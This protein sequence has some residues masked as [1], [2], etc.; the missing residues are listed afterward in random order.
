NAA[1]PLADRADD[2]GELLRDGVTHG[3]RNIDRGRAGIDR[4]LHKA[5]EKIQV[6]AGGVF[7]REFHVRAQRPGVGHGAVYLFKRLVARDFELALQMQIRAGQE[8]VDPRMTGLIQRSPRA[9][10]V[11][12]TGTGQSSNNRAAE[13]CGD[14]VY[15]PEVIFRSYGKTR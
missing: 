2:S 13:L 15:G 11:R 4:S 10:D 7:R 3:V 12:L 6:R 9:A 14:E 5:A 1:N 8:Y